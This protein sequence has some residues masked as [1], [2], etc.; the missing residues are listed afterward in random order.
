MLQGS[1][2]GGV[3]GVDHVNRG[4]TASGRC[5]H[6]SVLQGTGV[7]GWPSRRRHLSGYPNDASASRVLIDSKLSR[8]IVLLGREMT[9]LALCSVL[10]YAI[11]KTNILLLLLL[12]NL[13]ISYHARRWIAYVE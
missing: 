3:A 7:D 8:K 10:S 6:C 9:M 4:G 13:E 5:H 1:V 12:Y 2:G 11:N